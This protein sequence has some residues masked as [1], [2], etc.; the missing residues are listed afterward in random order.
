MPSRFMFENCSP[1]TFCESLFVNVTVRTFLYLFL[2]LCFTLGWKLL[3]HSDLGNSVLI[4]ALFG[5]LLFSTVLLT[6]NQ[7]VSFGSGA[8][9]KSFVRCILFSPLY[10]IFYTP[11]IFRSITLSVCMC[12]CICGVSSVILFV[13]PRLSS[14][15]FSSL[16][17]IKLTRFLFFSYPSI[18]SWFYRLFFLSIFLQRAADE[19]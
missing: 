6:S 19:G 12:T 15:Y 13:L 3:L 16:Y 2:C 8:F 17:S 9:W 10:N 5:W 4:L 7:H 1:V 11:C 18:S 14:R